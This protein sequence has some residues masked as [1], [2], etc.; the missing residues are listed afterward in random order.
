MQSDSNFLNKL[1]RAGMALASCALGLSILATTPAFAQGLMGNMDDDT[2]VGS[3]NDHEQPIN[4]QGKPTTATEIVDGLQQSP[5]LQSNS[6]Q[7]LQN[8]L[9]K[10]QNLA[11]Q[12]GFP[13]VPASYF[14]KGDKGGGVAALNTRLYLEGYLRVEGTQGQFATIFTTATQDGL[15]RFQRNHGLAVNGRVDEP[16]LAELNVPIEKRIATIQANIARLATYGEGLGERYIVVNIPAQQLETVSGGRVY[17][18]HNVI[19]GRPARPT[20]VV[21][22]PID[23][24]KF[25]PYWNAPLSIV[26]KDILPK[27]KNG[28]DYLEKIDMKIL[29]G[30]PNGPVIDPATLN[31]NTIVAQNYLFRQEPGPENA[32]ATAKI[33]F[34]SPFG[35]YLHDTPEKPLFNYNNRFFSSG[36][37][38]IQN[39]PQLVN[40]VLNGQ[41]GYNPDSIAN[42]AKTLERLDVPVQGAPQLRVA[43]LTAWPAAGGTVAF[44]NDIYQMDG[45]GFILGQ[46]MPVGQMSPD[47]QRFVLKPLPNTPPIDASEADG[48]G[49]FGSGSKAPKA[50][51]IAKPGVV[52]ISAERATGP[53]VNSGKANKGLF[54]WTA[55]R[56]QQAAAAAGQTKKLVK[57]PKAGDPAVKDAA[58]TDPAKDAT[59]TAIAKKDVKPADSKT[60]SADKTKPVDATVA[61]AKAKVVKPV[62][63]KAVASA[64][65]P[66]VKPVTKKP[67]CAAGVTTAAC[68]A[69]VITA[70]AVVPADA[71]ANDNV[72]TP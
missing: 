27:L 34:H 9:A 45:S 60:A 32:M 67:A 58:K 21:M 25:N 72:K 66:A 38:R 23:T 47:G 15:A 59:K 54:D 63:P 70:K 65:K 3:I 29:E 57:K 50:T 48:K 43:Y 33:E 55:Y 13:K 35:I 16:T 24:V 52:N 68:K 37:I 18:R 14:K 40:W 2:G 39:M 62:D 20:P 49:F 6:A 7:L 64:A 53:A 30:G 69:A 12:G 11:S 44:R 71:P 8:S 22:T 56:K 10:Y 19:V 41:D 4:P 5:M 61:G 17:E 28:N 51:T 42:M 46:P 1:R 31:F 26:R 36:C